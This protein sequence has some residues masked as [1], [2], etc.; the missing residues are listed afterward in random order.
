[1]AKSI[2]PTSKNDVEPMQEFKSVSF[3]NAGAILDALSSDTS[4]CVVETLRQAS[5]T[6]SGLAERLDISI[7]VATY[8][9]D[10]LQEV[11][12]I[13]VIDTCYST[14]GREMKVYTLVAEEVVLNI[15]SS[16]NNPETGTP[17]ESE[18]APH[19]PSMESD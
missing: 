12:L 6:P 5:D 13:K 15:S 17:S 14:R 16:T 8:H 10:Q 1:M 9:L 18:S 19:R 2:Y 3:E 11:G 4:R 7:Q